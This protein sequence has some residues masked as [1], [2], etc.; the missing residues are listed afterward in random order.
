MTSEATSVLPALDQPDPHRYRALAPRAPKGPL[1]LAALL[2]GAGPVEL[3]IG[4]GHGQ[5][6]YERGRAVPGHRIVGLEVKKKW[7]TL[8]AERCQKRGISNVT[9]W[10][11]DA[12]EVLPRI[13]EASVQRV[14]MHFPDPWWKRKHDKRRLTGDTLL[15]EVARI[16]VPGGEF[17][18]QTDVPDRVEVHLAAINAHALFLPGG[19]GGRLENNPYQARSNREARAELDGLPVYRTLAIR[20]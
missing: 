15:D 11:D 4:F 18:M 20:R 3:E 9:A 8:V 5:F 12:R 10:S 14:F 7:A 17:F 16:L 13:G 19:D 1:D 6:L 2:P